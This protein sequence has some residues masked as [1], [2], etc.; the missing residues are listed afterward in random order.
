MGLTHA[1]AV[2]IGVL[3]HMFQN[4]TPGVLCGFH[5]NLDKEPVFTTNFHSDNQFAQ[6]RDCTR[7]TYVQSRHCVA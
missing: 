6:S 3:A 4:S 2:I 7:R 5:G 1:L